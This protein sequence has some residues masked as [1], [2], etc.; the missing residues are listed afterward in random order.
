M[1]IDG[2]IGVRHCPWTVDGWAAGFNASIGKHANESSLLL[3]FTLLLSAVIDVWR[4]CRLKKRSE[5]HLD[6][7]TSPIS[8][9][10]L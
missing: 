6:G 5:E 2:A 10:S 9:L 4:R 8:I 1:L 3:L 7:N